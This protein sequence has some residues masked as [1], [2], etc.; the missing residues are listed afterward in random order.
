[1]EIKLLLKALKFACLPTL[2]V[3][4]LLFFG[5]FSISKAIAWISGDSTFAIVIRVLLVIAEIAL[6]CFMY[7]NYVE[8][9][10]LE[11]ILKGEGLSTTG[12]TQPYDRDIYRLWEDDKHSATFTMHKTTNE[13]TIVL[14]RLL[15]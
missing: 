9:E 4:T 1:M 15:R 3:L 13:N 5:F 12:I 14:T 2:S 7:Q 11:K 8:E 10:K 6:V